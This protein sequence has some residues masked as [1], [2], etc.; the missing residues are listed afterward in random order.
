MLQYWDWSLSSLPHLLPPVQAALQASPQAF[1]TFLLDPSTDPGLISLIQLHGKG[2]LNVYFRLARP[3]GDDF[4]Y[5][6]SICILSDYYLDP[7]V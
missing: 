7:H 2:I 3:A 5:M 6:A 4:N 1:T